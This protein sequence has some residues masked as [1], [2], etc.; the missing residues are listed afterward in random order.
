MNKPSLQKFMPKLKKG[1]HLFINSSL[2][3]DETYRDDVNVYEI[4]ASGIALAL[5]NTKVSNMVVLG[6][7]LAVTQLFT[8]DD[9]IDVMKIKFT[10][11]KAKLI[12]INRK[13]LEAGR[14]AVL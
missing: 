2:V 6:G 1:G 14:D 12:D 5:G 13:A 4:D 8:I 11:A 7:Y 10:G 9:I 3:T